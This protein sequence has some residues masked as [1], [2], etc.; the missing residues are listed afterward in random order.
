MFESLMEIFEPQLQPVY[1]R[2]RKEGMEKGIR[3]MIGALRDFGH[4]DAEIER[5]IVKNYGLSEAEAR[6]YL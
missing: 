1:E 6:E 5:A 4:G 2:I 3:G